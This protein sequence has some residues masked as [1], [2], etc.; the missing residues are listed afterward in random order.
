MVAKLVL[1]TCVE[2]ITV[3]THGTP[4]KFRTHYFALKELSK[5]HD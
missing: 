3:Y 1:I 4:M 5:G 2:Y